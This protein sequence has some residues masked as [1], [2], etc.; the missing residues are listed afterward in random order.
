MNRNLR[1]VLWAVLAICIAALSFGAWLPD[2]FTFLL[3]LCGA[4]TCGV[5]IESFADDRLPTNKRRKL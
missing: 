4:G 2:P 5:L 3:A 1:L